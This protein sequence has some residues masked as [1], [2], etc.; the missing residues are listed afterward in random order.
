[1]PEPHGRER[2]PLS[3]DAKALRD[4]FHRLALLHCPPT[5]RL[6][7]VLRDLDMVSGLKALTE[8]REHG[9]VKEARQCLTAWS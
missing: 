8:L 2:V 7:D 3:D 4:A 6:R 1:M 5:F 9:I